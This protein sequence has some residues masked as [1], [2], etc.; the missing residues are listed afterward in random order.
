MNKNKK[1]SYLKLDFLKKKEKLLKEISAFKKI[2]PFNKVTK[3]EKK[4]N[5][6]FLTLFTSNNTLRRISNCRKNIKTLSSTTHIQKNPNN[7]KEDYYTTHISLKFS[8]T[9]IQ[10]S[11]SLNEYICIV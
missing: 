2:P 1:K 3:I 8:H 9:N 4:K 7:S 10:N 11:I 6:Y 5:F